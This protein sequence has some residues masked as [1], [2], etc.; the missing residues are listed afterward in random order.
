MARILALDEVPVAL[1]NHL[2]RALRSF[3]EAVLLPQAERRDDTGIYKN[4]VFRLSGTEPNVPISI[5]NPR[6]FTGVSAVRVDG[7]VVTQLLKNHEAR[8]AAMRRLREA[9]PTD[10][11]SKSGRRPRSFVRQKTDCSKKIENLIISA[12]ATRG[13]FI[14]YKTAHDGTGGNTLLFRLKKNMFIWK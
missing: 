9:I 3:D 1:R 11:S 4:I 12:L 5:F 10:N 14:M 6:W 2:V 7:N 8:H 13:F